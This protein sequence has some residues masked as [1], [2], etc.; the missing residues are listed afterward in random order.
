MKCN[1]GGTGGRVGRLAVTLGAGTAISVGLGCG[2]ATADENDSSG[3][4]GASPANQSTPASPSTR[5]APSKPGHSNRTDDR[6][7]GVAASAFDGKSKTQLSL[8]ANSTRPT[9]RVRDTTVVGLVGADDVPQ[10]PPTIHAAV[11]P[12]PSGASTT[13]VVVTANVPTIR[14]TV[15]SPTGNVPDKPALPPVELAL[16]GG[17]RREIE[18]S[19]SQPTSSSSAVVSQE[20]TAPTPS[21]A[22]APGIAVPPEL[23]GAFQGHRPSV[24]ERSVHDGRSKCPTPDFAGHRSRNRLRVVQTNVNR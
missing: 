23:D 15:A 21:V 17:T 9:E 1:R 3:G 18:R 2:V 8:G 4:A 24:A 20:V 6:R 16:A 13:P 7:N 10:S 14:A 11:N 19:L 22:L 5:E 12:V